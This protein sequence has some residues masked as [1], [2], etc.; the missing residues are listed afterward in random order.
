MITGAKKY[1]VKDMTVPATFVSNKKEPRIYLVASETEDIPGGG[2]RK[3]PDT[4]C[5][6]KFEDWRLLVDNKEVLKLMLESDAFNGGGITGYR[7]DSE[8]KN[9]FWRAMGVLEEETVVRI[10]AQPQYDVKFTD[11]EFKGLKKRAEEVEEP[12]GEPA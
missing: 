4:G 2:F 10:K 3:K 7:I 6:V 1:R 11:L 5:M 9:G 8:D 12:E